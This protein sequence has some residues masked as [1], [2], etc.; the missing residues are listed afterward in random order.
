M[1]DKPNGVKPAEGMSK[2]DAVRKA[3]AKH[4]PKA[5]RKIL[6]KFIV[7]ELKVE[8]TPDQVSRLRSSLLLDAAKKA[9]SKPATNSA[10]VMNAAHP[11]RPTGGKVSTAGIGLEDIATAKDLLSR[12]SAADLKRLL[13]LLAG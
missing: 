7:E 13:D 12:S 11:V 1:A 2:T 6:Q 4:G 3:M 10:P 5:E 8:I 9:K